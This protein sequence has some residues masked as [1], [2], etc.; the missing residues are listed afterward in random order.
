MRKVVLF[1]LLSLAVCLLAVLFL[2]LP[3]GGGDRL[4][5][6]PTKDSIIDA[7]KGLPLHF[8]PNV[9]QV[10][11]EV[12]Y[13]SR[14]T[15]RSLF[16]TKGEAV[17]TWNA[18]SVPAAQAALRMKYVGANPD[19]TIVGLDEMSS[20]SNYFIGGRESWRSGVPHVAR[21]EYQQIYPGIDLIFYGNPIRLEYDFEVAPGI[22][23]STIRLRFAGADS[24]GLDDH[25]NLVLD[26][27]GD[28]VVQT[29]PQ[30]YQPSGDAAR[31]V[32]GGYELYG[33]GQVGFHIPEYDAG[34]PLVI[35]PTLVYSTYLGGDYADWVGGI[36]VD[37]HGQA[38]ITGSAGSTDFPTKN[39]LQSDKGVGEDAF[40]AKLDLTGGRLLFSTFFGGGGDDNSYAIVVSPNEKIFVSGITASGTTFPTLNALQP[41]L[42]GSLD[43]YLLKLNRTGSTLHFSTFLGGSSTEYGNALALDPDG[44]VIMV[45]ETQSSDFPTVKAYQKSSGGLGDIFVA[46]IG[47]TG[48]SMAYSTFLGG[49][50]TDGG[51]GVAVSE[52]GELFVTG[53][54]YSADF[55]TSSAFQPLLGG[56]RDAVV[57][58]M[59]STGAGLVYSTYLG[60]TGNEKGSGVA[61]DG[62]GHAYVTGETR[63]TDFPTEAALIGVFPNMS[64]TAFV[65]K[66]RPAGK[67][68]VYSTFLGGSF[69]DSGRG[70][71]V[72]DAGNAHVVGT[73]YSSTFPVVNPVMDYVSS[74]DIFLSILNP[75]GEALI[76][77]TTFGGSGHDEGQAVVLDGKGGVYI[78]GNTS[79]T[80]FPTLNAVQDNFGGG[81][82]NDAIV[83]KLVVPLDFFIASATRNGWPPISTEND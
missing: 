72:D 22:D 36:A 77:S 3:T 27:A 20:K 68:L 58:K 21:V 59:S 62:L 9:G 71:A 54:T 14:S 46:K 51:E 28:R 61:I 25:G 23:P 30:I 31:A 37:Q 6:T 78:V 19:P 47:A 33:E 55:P 12:A 70:I 83:A 29:A 60:G 18:S 76:S 40:V 63:S 8:E 15:G 48:A 57:L 34:Q 42:G 5:D 49:S 1:P 81:N 50:S 82:D 32:E 66:L 13:L 39:A 2:L 35:D 69:S 65:S 17:L 44:K 38:Y 10:A 56:G 74:R 7:F 26:V 24:L 80:D 16:L 73:T 11:P 4:P 41:T 43:A 75:P 64:D 79:S 67:N 52:D 53:Y 45:G